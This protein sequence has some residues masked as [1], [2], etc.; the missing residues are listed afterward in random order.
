MAPSLRKAQSEW[1]NQMPVK[2]MLSLTLT[3]ITDKIIYGI[4]IGINAHQK[5]AVSDQYEFSEN[6]ENDFDFNS[7][8]DA[9]KRKYSVQSLI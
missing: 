7:L 8:S 9:E 2:L 5:Q 1:L 6:Y 3:P 4:F